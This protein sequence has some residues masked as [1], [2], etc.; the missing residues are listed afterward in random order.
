MKFNVVTRF[1]ETI[2]MISL[3]HH[4]RS[5]KILDFQ[6]KLPFYPFTK[7]CIFSGFTHFDKSLKILTSLV[8]I[9]C[10]KNLLNMTKMIHMNFSKKITYN[11]K[12]EK[13]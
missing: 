6:P 4:L 2:L 10:T 9:S 11:I 8:F 13:W 7:N 12:K 1:H 5:R 3:F